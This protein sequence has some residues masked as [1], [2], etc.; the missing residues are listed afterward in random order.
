MK[1]SEEELLEK[2]RAVDELRRERGWDIRKCCEKVGVPTSVYL[3]L[4]RGNSGG[5]D[6]DP[7]V[8]EASSPD[9]G[10][11]SPGG[12]EATN[13]SAPAPPCEAFGLQGLL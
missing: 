9:K 5:V 13:P 6:K 11:E 10:S 4:K 1:S 7:V 2:V 3:K 8:G 12:E